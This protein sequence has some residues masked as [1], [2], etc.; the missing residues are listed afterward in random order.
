[1]DK[2]VNKLKNKSVIVRYVWINSENKKK[3]FCDP[4]KYTHFVSEDIEGK[5]VHTWIIKYFLIGIYIDE[6]D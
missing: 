6:P 5:S 2:N 3:V 4:S 1:M